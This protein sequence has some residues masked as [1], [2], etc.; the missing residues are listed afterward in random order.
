MQHECKVTVL[1]TKVFPELQQQYLANPKSGPCP[2]FS[3][4]IRLFSSG[5][6]NRTIL[7]SHER[8]VLR[9]SVGYHQPLHL[10]G[11]AGRIDHA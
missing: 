9:R 10:R 5:R 8:Q 2:F 6:K 3:P 11:F 4:A 7:P 1:E